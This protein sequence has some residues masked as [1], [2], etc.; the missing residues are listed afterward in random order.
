[1]LEIYTNR[2]FGRRWEVG[3]QRSGTKED[4]CS[5]PGRGVVIVGRKGDGS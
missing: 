4:V 3:Y 5:D 2:I 1:M